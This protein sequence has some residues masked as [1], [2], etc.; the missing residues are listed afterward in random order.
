M[1]SWIF[2]TYKGAPTIY[3]TCP[4][5]RYEYEA[6]EIKGFFPSGKLQSDKI[7]PYCPMCGRK[8]LSQREQIEGISDR[9][10]IRN[11]FR[12]DENKAENS[13]E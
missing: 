2:N 4:N 1:K 10:I 3:A 9:R 13:N 8:H 5:C 12:K 7:F 6:G 11:K